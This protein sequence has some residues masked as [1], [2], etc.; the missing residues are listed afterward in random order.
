MK[1]LMA[2]LLLAGCLV[3][4]AVAAGEYAV[5]KNTVVS[6]FNAADLALMKSTVDEALAAEKDGE[7]LDWK[8]DRTSAG[9]S[10]TPFARFDANGM[11]C[12]RA[13]VVSTY[14]ARTG[15]GVY[16]FCE[17][18]AGQWKIVGPDKLPN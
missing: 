9:G 7:T 5:L 16:R 11:A 8:N 14:R 10:I 13:R 1:K 12:R 15:S 17:K 4:G 6:K 3:E 18:P 2:L